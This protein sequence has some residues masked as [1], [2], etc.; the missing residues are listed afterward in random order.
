MAPLRGGPTFLESGLACDVSANRVWGS[1]PIPALGLAIVSICLLKCSFLGSW[2]TCIG[3]AKHSFKLIQSYGKTQ[4]NFLANPTH[5]QT[6]LPKGP[7]RGSE[8]A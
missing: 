1:D 8:D 5:S 2:A 4:M 3:L 6:V 7:H